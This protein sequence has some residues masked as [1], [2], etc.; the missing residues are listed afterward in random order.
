M[1]FVGDIALPF[2][3]AINYSALSESFYSKVWFG[4]LEGAIVEEDDNSI[5]AVYNHKDAIEDLIQ[6]FDFKG[7]ALANNQLFD[8]GDFSETL[9]FLDE[10]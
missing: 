8:T 6:N 1:V 2:N 7:F 3:G 9:K 5:D 10:K 4:N